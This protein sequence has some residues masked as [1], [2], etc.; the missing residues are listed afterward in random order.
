MKLTPC[1]LLVLLGAAGCAGTKPALESAPLE[2]RQSVAAADYGPPIELMPTQVAKAVKP[3]RKKPAAKPT[4]TKV[5]AASTAVSTPRPARSASTSPLTPAKKH[6]SAP[7]ALNPLSRDAERLSGWIASTRDNGNAPYIVIDKRQARMWLFDARGTSLGST[8]I[9]LG[10][11][12]GDHTVPGIG[13]KPLDQITRSE[14]TTPAGRF[15][16]EP[17]RNTKGEDIFWVDYDAAVSMHRVRATVAAERR[18]ERLDTISPYDNRISWGCINVPVAFYERSIQPA[19][20]RGRG[21]VYI[22][23]ERESVRVT[24]AS[25]A[26]RAGDVPI[27]PEL[28]AEVSEQVSTELRRF[29]A[30]QRP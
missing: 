28:L 30:P 2:V 5:V 16:I 8:P 25:L 18:L 26:E 23:P 4:T 11:A 29:D 20:A 19:F 1:L 6:A 9:L 24:F 15:P 17:G 10:A 7:S 21:V 22:L 3:A 13:D 27:R 14:R 12:R